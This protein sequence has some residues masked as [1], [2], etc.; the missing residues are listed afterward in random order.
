[1]IGLKADLCRCSLAFLGRLDAGPLS[2]ATLGKSVYLVLGLAVFIGMASGV[3]TLCG[4]AC[5]A[6]ASDTQAS[7]AHPYCQLSVSID[8]IRSSLERQA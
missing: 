1:M 8:K 4:Q 5:P 7:L 6:P 2:I 3:E